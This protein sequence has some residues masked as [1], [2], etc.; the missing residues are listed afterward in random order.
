MLGTKYGYFAVAG[1]ANF[2]N[3][4]VP[5]LLAA[6]QNT[7]PVVRANVASMFDRDYGAFADSR[8]ADAAITWLND[9]DPEI[10]MH[11]VMILTAYGNWKPQY[12]EAVMAMLRD[13]DPGVRHAA[14]FALPRFRGDLEKYIPSLQQM[15]NAPDD[16]ARAASLE[17]LD[18][19]GVKA[20]ISR[21]DLLSFFTSPDYLVLNAAFTQLGGQH[22]KFPT[23]KSS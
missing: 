18:R 6:F 21:A 19:L 9:S 3:D 8:L 11:A 14:I 23:T 20:E 15:L 17:I 10:R 1:L 22:G 5:P 16:N 4:A 13:K 2:H 7:N 12:A